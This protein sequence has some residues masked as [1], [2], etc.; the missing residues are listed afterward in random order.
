MAN[1]LFPI[2]VGA[3]LVFTYARTIQY[4]TL[5]EDVNK[6]LVEATM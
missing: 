1:K 6:A 4:S 2:F 5:L 3:L